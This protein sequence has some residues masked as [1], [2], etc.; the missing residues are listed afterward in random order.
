MT[1]LTARGDI[2]IAEI[3]VYAFLLVISLL[4]CVRHGFKGQDGWILL[5]IFCIL[6]LV[7]SVL[8]IVVEESSN[9]STGVIVGEFTISNIALTPLHMAALG[10]L[11]TCALLAFDNTVPAMLNNM[12]RIS[13]IV[14]AAA[15]ILGIVSAV[16][17]NSNQASTTGHD[18]Q[19]AAILLITAV[20][21]FLTLFALYLLGFVSIGGQSRMLALGVTFALPFLCVR[22]IYSLV[23][24]FSTAIP[25][26][27]SSTTGS[28]QI[29]LGMDVIME[30]VVVGVLA[31][32]GL[33]LQNYYSEGSPRNLQ[34]EMA[35][36]KD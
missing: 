2:A 12:L 16:E 28:W 7:A 4:N 23:G 36:M 34:F 14:L 18:L 26:N 10:F 1:H 8:V 9:P 31:V 27:F 19:K 13:R 30:F 20:F 24:V 6:R 5:S 35:N 3:V 11:I 32:T 21:C 22:I 15:I 33:L 29:Y 25:N 17:I